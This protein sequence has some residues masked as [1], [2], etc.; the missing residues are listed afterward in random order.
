MPKL[1]KY[2]IAYGGYNAALDRVAVHSVGATSRIAR[3]KMC[4]IY[5]RPPDEAW[6]MLKKDGWR[7][8]KIGMVLI[9]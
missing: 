5:S 9:R 4:E 3:R 7:I 8:V 1:E 2:Q 6:K